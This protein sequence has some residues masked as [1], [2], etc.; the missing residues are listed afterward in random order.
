MYFQ[1]CVRIALNLLVDLTEDGKLFEPDLVS[2][3]VNNIESW[4]DLPSSIIGIKL[5]PLALL[6]LGTPTISDI[7]GN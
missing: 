3:K 5:S 1:S 7:V 4:T 2:S 6:S